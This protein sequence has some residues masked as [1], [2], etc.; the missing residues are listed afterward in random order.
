MRC[1]GCLKVP[2]GKRR[3]AMYEKHKPFCSQFCKDLYENGKPN[4]Y[5]LRQ[6]P[7]V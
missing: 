2:I 3:Q 5:L 7:K 4:P 6:K 1:K